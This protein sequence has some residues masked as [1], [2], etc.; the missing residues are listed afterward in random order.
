MIPPLPTPAAHLSDGLPLFSESQLLAYRAE[1]IEMCAKACDDYATDK[2]SLYKGRAPYKGNEAGR[3]NPHIQG[4]SCGAG[5]C[6]DAIKEL[7]K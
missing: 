7:L 2:W 4:E 5:D 3:A 6:A 1:V